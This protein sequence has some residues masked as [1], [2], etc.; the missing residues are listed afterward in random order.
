MVVLIKIRLNK[1]MEKLKSIFVGLIICYCI[2]FYA[3]SEEHKKENPV[4]KQPNEI[5]WIQYGLDSCMV[6]TIAFSQNNIF[7]A[8][9]NKGLYK[10]LDYGENWIRIENEISQSFVTCIFVKDEYVLAGTSTKGIY[11][12]INDGESW[13]QLGLEGILIT[14]ISM[15]QENKIYVGSRGQGIFVTTINHEEW[16]S[17]NTDFELQ[18]FS[19]LLVTSQNKIFAG[20]TGVYRSDDDGKTWELKN[21]G[22]GNWSVYSLIFDDLGN[23]SAG[24]DQGGFFNSKDLGENWEKLNNG[25]TNTEITS[26]TINYDEYLFAGTWRGGIFRSVDRALN[27]EEVNNGLENWQINSLCVSPNNYLFTGTFRGLYRTKDKL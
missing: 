19:A 3:C 9:T 23:I 1:K 21:I 6:Y 16:V 11:L 25:M 24:T 4:L 20:G 7:L 10:S 13:R 18:T 26:L 5:S 2:G 17:A 8:G 27:W 22:L 14:S 15:N 12:S